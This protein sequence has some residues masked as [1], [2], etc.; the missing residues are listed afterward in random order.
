MAIQFGNDKIK[1]IYVGS[2]KIK[3]VYNGSELVYTAHDPRGYWVHKDTGVVT[4]FGADA[5]FI[6]G[7]VM[8]RPDWLFDAVEIKLCS[9]INEFELTAAETPWG[10]DN[11]CL[12]FIDLNLKTGEG[13]N[14]VLQNIDMSNTLVNTIGVFTFYSCTSLTSITLPEGMTSIRNHAFNN[15]SSLTSI[16]LPEGMTSIGDSAFY[17]CPSL[18]SITLPEGLT[19]IG[20]HTFYRC[21]SLTS[22]TLQDGLTSIG[23]GAFN[24]CTSLASITFPSSL[25]SIGTVAFYNCASLTSITLPEGL[26]SIGNNVFTGCTSLSLV[27]SLPTVPPSLGTYF[28]ENTHA[29]LVIKVPAQSVNAYKTATNWGYYADK[30]SAI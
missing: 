11:L 6:T 22:I 28:F 14:N 23:E 7:G 19:S 12:V 16:T 10:P 5:D 9:G 21:I 13:G 18:T 17:D 3:E 2:D 1:E 30:I 15:C 26:M 24:R 8:S 4:Y 29:N 20:N 27:T 25:T